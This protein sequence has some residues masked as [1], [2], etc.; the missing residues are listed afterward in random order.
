MSWILKYLKRYV[1]LIAV[2][3]VLFSVIAAALILLL[4]ALFM[5]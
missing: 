4:G 2:G 3:A 5:I 1:K